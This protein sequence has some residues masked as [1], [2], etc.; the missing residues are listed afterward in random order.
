MDRHNKMNERVKQGNVDLLMIGDSI[1]QGWEGA[2]KEVWK[3]FYGKRNAVREKVSGTISKNL[4][5]PRRT[6]F[7]CGRAAV[8]ANASAVPLGRA[9]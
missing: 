9:V 4:V 8:V 5:G 7:P 3:K 6:R 2:G 1:T